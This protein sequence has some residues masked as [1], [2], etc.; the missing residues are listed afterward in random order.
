MNKA[1]IKYC[2]ILISLLNT[3]SVSAQQKITDSRLILILNRYK[4]LQQKLPVEKA[5][6]QTDKPY[7][8]VGDTI[9][10]KAYVFNADYLNA[11]TRSGLLYVELSNDS[12]N[13]VT[14]IMLPV[15][16][17]LALGQIAIN[18]ADVPEG[19]YT[20]RAYTNWMRNFGEDY[21][22]TKKLYITGKANTP[23][24]VNVKT[25]S[26]TENDKQ[27][28]HAALTFT[29][30]DKFLVLLRE[31]QVK[32]QDGNRTLFRGKT[33]T[34]LNGMLNI[35]FSLSK[36]TDIANL[37][38]HT[39]DLRKG[40]GNRQ[41]NI[42][43]VLN[44]P[45]NIDLQFMPEGGNLISGIP[46]KVGFKAINEDGQGVNINGKIYD[47]SQQ[48]VAVFSSIHK[49]MGAFLFTPQAT[50]SYTAKVLLSNGSIKTYQL[51][52][53]KSSG[54]AM[55][56][57]AIQ[58]DSLLISLSITP[59][60]QTTGYYLM[61]QARGVVCFAQPVNFDKQSVI[62]KVAQSSFPSGITRF[63]LLDNRAQPLNERIVYIDHN[64]NLNISVKPD[65]SNYTARDS[66]ALQIKVTDNDGKP[67]MGSFSLAVTDNGQ[68]TI[69]SLAAN[70]TNSLLL[71]DDLKGTIEEPGY[72]FQNAAQNKAQLDNLMLT[73][74]W[75]GYN[76]EQVTNTTAPVK[77]EAEPEFTI[78]GSVSNIFNKP[79]PG[80]KIVLM[81]R[82]PANVAT[83]TTTVDG[84]FSFA[85]LALSD[86]TSFFVEG[87]NKRGKAFGIGITVDQT[88]PPVFNKPATRYMPWFVNTDTSFQKN[89]TR[90]ISQRLEEEKLSGNHLLKDVIVRE[91]KIVK[92]SLN[93][94][95]PGEADQVLDD[96]VMDKSGDMT[97]GEVLEKNVPG[98]DIRVPVKFFKNYYMVGM[99]IVHLFIDGIDT[100]THGEYFETKPY[101]DN[102]TAKDIAGIEIM[103][104][105]KYKM[106]YDPPNPPKSWGAIANE[107]GSNP[108]MFIEVTTRGKVGPNYLKTP[109]TYLYKPVHYGIAKQFYRPAYIVKT[110]AIVKDLRSTIHWAPNIITDKEGKATIS[111]Y[112]S[113]QP[114]N[115]TITVE[116]SDMNGNIGSV[117]Q[118]LNNTKN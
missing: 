32:V 10:F 97:L 54:T 98:F 58:H 108:P 23:W 38:L 51:P 67:V 83:T 113:D 117:A 7:Y 19:S 43:L 24:F 114:G 15:K 9:W 110:P 89:I 52:A 34:D 82:K 37:S 74:G 92:G 96:K 111:F 68:V 87:T 5:Y 20:L 16:Y 2:F 8:T 63:S 101:L 47:S 17:G 95:G 85:G 102:F 88:P 53:V 40:E 75:V 62:F 71:T 84:R 105:V 107:M 116:G 46:S 30:A 11:S 56:I 109:G 90:A 4:G 18:E 66:V 69:D 25:T 70:L 76:W 49:G 31:M 33:Q 100:K 106:L 91:K 65:K 94:N 72:Y 39:E 118:K 27:T 13:V 35:N 57:K 29:G 3:Y 93:L 79:V 115:Y 103:N 61:G 112:A 6:L 44:R 50:G 28:I 22:F 55:S 81:S 48:E 104:S 60:L 45:E 1:I 12:A 77:F 41:M 80:S 78:K 42:P 14:R 73:Q 86:S 36:K 99:R 64:D 21:I 26:T 59:G